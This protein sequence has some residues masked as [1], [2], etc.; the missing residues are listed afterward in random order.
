MPRIISAGRSWMVTAVL[1]NRL[2][3]PGSARVS[4]TAGGRSESSHLDHLARVGSARGVETQKVD[5]GRESGPVIV[6]AGPRDF[7]ESDRG[8]RLE[9]RP[10]ATSGNVE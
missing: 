8:V 10:H 7:V 3:T 9:Q 5:A 2:F 6:V 4:T 1:T